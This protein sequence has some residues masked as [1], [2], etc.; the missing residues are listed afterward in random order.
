MEGHAGATG[1]KPADTSVPSMRRS[2]LLVYSPFQLNLDDGDLCRS[3]LCR[4]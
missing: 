3:R 2:N 1:L 4:S